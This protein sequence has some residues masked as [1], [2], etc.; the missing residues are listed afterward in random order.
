MLSILHIVYPRRQ[1]TC[2]ELAASEREVIFIQRSKE[3]VGKYPNILDFSKK[4]NNNQIKKQ[5]VTRKH[6]SR[7]HCHD[8]YKNVPLHHFLFKL[9]TSKCSFS[10]SK[11]FQ[12]FSKNPIYI[13]VWPLIIPKVINVTCTKSLY[14]CLCMYWVAN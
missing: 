7:V 9:S 13:A 12:L 8:E 6:P 4:P 1:P 3:R 2:M 5:V 11:I 14:F 10:S